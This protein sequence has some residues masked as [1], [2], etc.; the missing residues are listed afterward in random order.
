MGFWKQNIPNFIYDMNYEK[1]I[2]NARG[3][4][5]NLLNFCDL[6]WEQDCLDFHNNKRPIKTV[7]S[8]QAR[9]SIYNSSIDSSKNYEKFLPILFS[10]LDSL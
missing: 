2:L 8:T 10:S 7:S 3:E 1:L 6:D 9:Q 4:I 5:K